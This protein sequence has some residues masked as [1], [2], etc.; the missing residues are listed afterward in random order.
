MSQDGGQGT[1][2]GPGQGACGS[3]LGIPESWLP[4]LP[5]ICVDPESSSPFPEI[6]HIP[7]HS[8]NLCTRQAPSQ[9]H[10]GCSI[11]A[12]GARPFSSSSA[13]RSVCSEHLESHDHDHASGLLLLWWGSQVPARHSCGSAS[14]SSYGYMTPCCVDR[15]RVVSLFVR[16]ASGE[17]AYLVPCGP[18]FSLLGYKQW[19]T[20]LSPRAHLGHT[21]RLPRALRHLRGHC[22]HRS[23]RMWRPSVAACGMTLRSTSSARLAC[24]RTTRSWRR[25][26]SACRSRCLCLGRTRQVS[27]CGLRAPW[28]APAFPT[29]QLRA[30]RRGCGVGGGHGVPVSP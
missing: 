9:V 18:A 5:H 20:V 17:F 14:P 29:A 12:P 10:S 28:H 13:C 27:G 1:Q 30:A 7:D 11:T 26:I 6:I 8:L 16:R 3:R 25:R 4:H 22:P 2:P 19:G 15:P 21:S 24:C 23:T